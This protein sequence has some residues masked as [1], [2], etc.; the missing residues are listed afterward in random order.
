MTDSTSVDIIENT[1]ESV[2]RVKGSANATSLAQAISYAITDNKRVVLRAI[3]AGAVNQ[4]AKAMAI[5]RGLVAT[6][7]LDLT[8]RPGFTTV[9]GEEGEVSAMTFLV[10]VN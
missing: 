10:I 4:A 9:N 7:G 8:F 1:E 6:R 2:L 3:G 5:A